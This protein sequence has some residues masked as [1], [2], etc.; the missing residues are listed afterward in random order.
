MKKLQ[1]ALGLSKPLNIF[2]NA[3]DLLKV[4]IESNFYLHVSITYPVNA[5]IIKYL[6]P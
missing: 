6:L 3:I 4:A 5:F 1:L 2:E